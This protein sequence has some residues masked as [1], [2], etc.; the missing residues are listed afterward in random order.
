MSADRDTWARSLGVESVATCFASV[1]LDVQLRRC[2]D[3]VRAEVAARM[4]LG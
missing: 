1:T 4:T 2:P 3:E